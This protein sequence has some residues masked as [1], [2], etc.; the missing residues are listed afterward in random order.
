MALIFTYLKK[1]KTVFLVTMLLLAI[2]A[3]CALFQPAL[4]S[5]I[6]DNGIA[7]MSVHSVLRYGLFMLALTV[8]GAIVAILRNITSVSTSQ[9]LG[10]ELRHDIYSHTLHLSEANIDKLDAGSII[11]RITNDV[12]QVQEFMNGL[13][14]IIMK[15]PFMFIGSVVLTI[16]STPDEAPFIFAIVIIVAILIFLNMKISYPR[17]GRVQRMMDGLN[18]R[19][20]DFLTGI[21]I[22][23]AFN[24]ENHEK[25][26]FRDSSSAVGDANVAALSS[27]AVFSPLMSFT[28]NA[29]IVLLLYLSR[30]QKASEIGKLMASVNY[31]TQ[32]LFSITSISNSLNTATRAQASALRIKEVLDEENLQAEGSN[33]ISE[34]SPDIEFSS[35]S[36]FY[37][38]AQKPSLEDIS[39]RIKKGEK[40]GIIGPTGSGKSTLIKLIPRLYDASSGS[41]L[42]GGIPIE[43]IEE[44]ALRDSIS[45][46]FQKAVLFSG[47]IRDNLLWGCSEAGDEEIV[48]AARFS[49]SYSFIEKMPEGFDSV[50]GQGGVNL[51][52]GQRQRIAIARAIIHKPKILILDDATSALDAATERR[53]LDNISALS[54]DMTVILISQRIS[55]VASMDRVIC[56]NNGRIEMIGTHSEL[57]GAS[58]TYKS[59]ARSQLGASYEE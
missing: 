40:I 54:D 12:V 41:I 7:E 3:A 42:I 20:R 14:R 28:I 17:F 38:R 2:E 43:D 48:E 33:A 24:G 59:L 39:F 34:F 6:V 8:L 49:E 55:S 35:V 29:G 5:Y 44:K 22:V 52:G 11:T 32:M 16:V 50:L 4:M 21:R 13:M 25:E 37:N 26:L 56:M 15:A 36:F 19:A 58:D 10:E 57:M 46:V 45:I 51:S 27:I 31:M 23:K 18:T 1:H 53:V 9:C 47:T 30:S